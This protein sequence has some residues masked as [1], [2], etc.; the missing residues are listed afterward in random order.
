MLEVTVYRKPGCGLCDQAE[1]TLARIS[2]RLPLKVVLVDIE[3]DGELQA[4]YG[5]HIPVV[6]VGD[7]EVAR[8]PLSEGSLELSLRA[9]AAG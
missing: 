8:A 2:K 6:T 3:S 1:A 4:R 5:M 9:L 7:T